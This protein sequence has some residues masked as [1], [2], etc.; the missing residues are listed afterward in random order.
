MGLNLG[1]NQKVTV[2]QV[3]LTLKR[4][5]EVFSPLRI[6]HFSDAHLL[7]EGP[8]QDHL[9]AVLSSH[10]ADMIAFTGDVLHD[11]SRRGLVALEFFNRLSRLVQPR[12]GIHLVRG[13]HDNQEAVFM[14][15][16]AGYSLML[17]R[18]RTMGDGS[19]SWHLIGVDDPRWSPQRRP[20]RWQCHELGPTVSN[21]PP[22]TFKLVLSHSPDILP[23]AAAAGVDLVLAG[24]THGGQIRFPLVGALVTRTNISQRYAWGLQSYNGTCCHTTSGA[25]CS[26]PPIRVNCPP[27][28]VV[29]ELVRG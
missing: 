11:H 10:P 3:R 7:G 23:D 28:V 29:L 9:L 14:L 25:G 1:Y 13:N 6:L 2:K 4:L 21:L 22:D 12:L 27:E 24:H 16:K 18:H 8:Q 26:F 17:N 15:L 20:R 5:P 19:S